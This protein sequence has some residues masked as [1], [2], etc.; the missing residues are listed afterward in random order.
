MEFT[1][2]TVHSLLIT[3]YSLTIAGG[4]PANIFIL[5][6]FIRYKE[7][8]TFSNSLLISLSIGDLLTSVILSPLTIAEIQKVQSNLIQNLARYLTGLIAISGYTLISISFYRF[9]KISQTEFHR[10]IKLKKV[11]L[12][13]VPWCAPALYI[14]T[15]R[16]NRVLNNFIVI[17]SIPACFLIVYVYS[18]KTQ[19]ILKR[20]WVDAQNDVIKQKALKRN[21]KALTLINWVVAMT[22]LSSSGMVVMRSILI[23]EDFID[24]E[25]WALIKAWEY[26]IVQTGRLVWCINAIVNPL[27]YFWKHPMF[28][29]KAS[30]VLKRKRLRLVMHP[31][32][33]VVEPTD[34]GGECKHESATD[35][36]SRFS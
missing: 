15:K 23:T 7:I 34:H 8:Q 14:V 6:L 10:R 33:A 4:A 2:S 12:F 29:K 5:Y 22:F 19:N 17:L 32:I 27:L 18:R 24:P 16:L 20:N 21:Q 26:E 35:E 3:G 25:E 36:Y 1:R 31:K 11:L 13:V 30:L 28:R 9:I